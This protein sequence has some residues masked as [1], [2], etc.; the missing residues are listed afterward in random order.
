M[1]RVAYVNIDVVISD[2]TSDSVFNKALDFYSNA[3][4]S[5]FTTVA[6]E[7]KLDVRVPAEVS[8]A[9]NEIGGLKGSKVIVNWAFQKNEGDI[10]SVA[11]IGDNYVVAYVADVKEKGMMG[12]EDAR[13]EV[14][15]KIRTEKKG[16]MLI[17]KYKDAINAATL[18]E[19]AQKS[20]K[21]INTI[22]EVNFHS[23]FSRELGRD[24]KVI[25]TCFGLNEKEVSEP[26]IGVKG[27]YVVMTDFYL[28]PKQVED[29]Y[30][31]AKAKVEQAIGGRTKYGTY[32]A[33]QKSAD[34]EDLRFK[35]AVTNL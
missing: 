31:D 26:V 6:K 33:I 23:P 29:D 24:M 15:Y 17:E 10:S 21:D 18:E 20:G 14:E 11:D 30:A 3:T 32:S 19:I 25:G 22:S 13:K 34:I 27:V 7:L 1:A 12:V 9:S 28:D 4:K 2:A 16:Q 35:I 5:D 8:V